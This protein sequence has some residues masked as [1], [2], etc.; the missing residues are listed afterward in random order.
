METYLLIL[1]ILFALL[2]ASIFYIGL[3]LK[4]SLDRLD[5]ILKKL[6]DNLPE[7]VEELKAALKGIRILIEG[8]K[9]VAGTV[10]K[11]SSLLDALTPDP[12]TLKALKE[13][14]ILFL[15]PIFS[16]FFRTRGVREDKENKE[17]GK[18]E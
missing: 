1:T 13:V 17:H 18:D 9:P 15:S 12:K 7:I 8:L 2:C 10:S 6:D 14:L 4:K 11:I 5:S 16:R 3:R